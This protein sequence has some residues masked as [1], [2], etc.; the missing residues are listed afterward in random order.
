MKFKLWLYSLYPLRF[1]YVLDTTAHVATI[2]TNKPP[3]LLQG[4]EDTEVETL[5]I[6]FAGQGYHVIVRNY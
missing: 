3:L 1:S 5:S 2:R 4:V 6:H